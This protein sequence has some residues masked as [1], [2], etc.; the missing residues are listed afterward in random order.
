MTVKEALQKVKALFADVPPAV[1]APVPAPAP[2]PAA[3]KVVKTIDGVEL[4]IVQAGDT[5]AVGDLVSIAGAPAPAADYTLEDKSVLT[6]D[7]TGA[8]TAVV[9]APPI[10]VPVPAPPPPPALTMEQRMATIEAILSKLTNPSVPA[11]M[12]AEKDLVALTPDAVQAMYAKFATGTSDDR[13]ANLETMVKAL[14]EC[15][16]GYQIRQGLENTAIQAY[17]DSV[18]MQVGALVAS[19]QKFE[20]QENKIKKQDE[21]IQGLFGLVELMTKEP[22]V[23][24]VTLTGNKKEQFERAKKKEDKFKLILESIT[25]NAKTKKY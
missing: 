7:A 17:K 12:S 23:A 4:S 13:I 11:A 5:P 6:V 1:P 2:A 14:M 3:G 10:T 16:F 9:A 15:N 19:T 24:P 22:E 18:A 20:A 25:A 8:I 21:I